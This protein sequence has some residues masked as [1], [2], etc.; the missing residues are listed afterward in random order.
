MSAVVLGSAGPLPYADRASTSYAVN[1]NGKTHVLIDQGPSSLRRFVE[2]RM[3]L[4]DLDIIALSHLHIDHINDFAAFLKFAFFSNRKRELAVAGPDQN[5]YFPNIQQYLHSLLKDKSGAYR[6]LSS[7]LDG[8]AGFFLLK[9]SVIKAKQSLEQEVFKDKLYTLSAIA[10]PHGGVPALAYKI[11]NHRKT[12]IFAGDQNLS[13]PAFNK[14]AHNADV[15]IVHFAIPE[16]SN[17]VITALHATP[18]QIGKAA[19]AINPKL[20]VLSHVMPRS[21]HHLDQN[22]ASI[23]KNFPGSIVV[24]KDLQCF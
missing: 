17:S 5:K 1:I 2:A 12:I 16:T 20:L 6:Y 4:K 8:S 10:V 18:T 3:R 24:A 19:K 7:Y 22:I 11:S 21:M 9:P 23:R 13:S 14:F 15:L